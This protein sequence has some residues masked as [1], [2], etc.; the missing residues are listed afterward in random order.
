MRKHPDQELLLSL[1][2]G[3]DMFLTQV[4]D[5]R[6]VLLGVCG[7]YNYNHNLQITLSLSWPSFNIRKTDMDI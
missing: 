5:K 3:E 6:L 4:L 1:Q 7:T 2:S